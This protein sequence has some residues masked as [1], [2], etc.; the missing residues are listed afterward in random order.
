LICA[1]FPVSAVIPPS[2]AVHPDAGRD[3]LSGVGLREWN[4]FFNGMAVKV[5]GM[6]DKGDGMEDE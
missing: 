3:P 4:P 6:A 1:G 2:T 5:S